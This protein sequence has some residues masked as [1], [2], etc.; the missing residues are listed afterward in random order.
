M[1]NT[2]FT[3]FTLVTRVRVSSSHILIS[4]RVELKQG[5]KLRSKPPWKAL[6]RGDIFK[7][8]KRGHFEVL[9]KK[10]STMTDAVWPEE[11]KNGLRFKIRPG[12]DV[13][14]ARSQLVTHT[15]SSCTLFVLL[16]L[17]YSFSSVLFFNFSGF[18]CLLF[19]ST[20]ETGT[21]LLLNAFTGVPNSR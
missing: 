17:L 13:V 7:M 16:S 15:Q 3:R 1:K 20:S 10:S 21:S 18:F 12:Y 8:V 6:F 19:S 11:S 14:P 5:S 2:E 4:H 9:R